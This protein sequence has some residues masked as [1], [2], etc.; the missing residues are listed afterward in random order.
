MKALNLALLSFI[1]TIDVPTM[2]FVTERKVLSREPAANW[3]SVAYYM[4]LNSTTET[5]AE[6]FDEGGYSESFRRTSEISSSI[7]GSLHASIRAMGFSEDLLEMV[8]H[9][10][11]PDEMHSIHDLEL[12]VVSQ[13][14]IRCF[15]LFIASCLVSFSLY[16]SI[17]YLKFEKRM[18][19]F[20]WQ[21]S[22]FYTKAYFCRRAWHLRWFTITPEN[23]ASIPNRFDP[24]KHRMT[25]P[26]FREIEID[27]EHLLLKI[28][29]PNP[30][31]RDCTFMLSYILKRFDMAS[32]IAIVLTLCF[33]SHLD[34]T[35]ASSFHADCPSF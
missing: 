19:C 28:I 32:L 18:S 34:G 1:Q 11:R 8:R 4:P 15:G 30:A 23:I 25:Y 26:R 33:L 24:E 14:G 31:K 12:N 13:T 7:R 10:E 29:N 3:N 17:F 16:D 22:F 5:P 9:T 2:P 35:I 21:R 6:S 20:L 27:E